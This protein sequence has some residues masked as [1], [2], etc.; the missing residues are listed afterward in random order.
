MPA[1]PR[2]SIVTPSYNQGRFLAQTIESIQRQTYPHW[3]H[4]VVD[5]LSTDNT[6]EVLGRY[7]HLRILRERD[8]GPAE[9]VNK[10][11]RL[12]SGE[13]LCFL[14]S[15][16][17]LLP[18]ALERVARDLQPRRGR[19]VVVGRCIYVAETGTPL[20]CEHSWTAAPSRRRVLAAWK[21]NCIPQ[22]STFWSAEAW[23]RCGPLDE[24]EKLVFDYDF[25]CRLSRVYSFTAI[26]EILS[27]YRLHPESK[28]FFSRE[29]QARARSIRI[30]KRYWGP[31][32]GLDRFCLRL[33]RESWRW[34]APARAAT[35][36]ALRRMRLLNR[37]SP[38]TL[39][40]RDFTGVHGD[41]FVGPT[42]VTEIDTRAPDTH[43]ELECGPV[44]GERPPRVDLDVRVDGRPLALEC[45]AS[46]RHLR[47]RAPLARQCA[48][49]HQLSIHARPAIVPHE[50]L[51]NGDFRPLTFHLQGLRVVG[52]E[53][54][55]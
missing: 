36:W 30:S 39:M 33:S 29:S 28:S 21:G 25:M 15:D 5:G 19:H 22:P 20:D 40:W 34:S 27:T 50:L 53:D 26:D 49:K 55:E 54:G 2:I 46:G 42:F 8:S 43:L 44:V 14:N 10:G 52:Q 3:E 32:L 35:K 1:A 13:I 7:A 41:G 6:A 24:S 4:V 11:M 23:R 45:R 9:A 38:L 12:A 17:T 48:G 37:Q 18:G 51:G 16:D 47:I 31:R